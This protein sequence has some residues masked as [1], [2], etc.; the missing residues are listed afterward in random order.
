MAKYL[1]T[2]QT[3]STVC[4]LRSSLSSCMPPL[5]STTLNTRTLSSFVTT[6]C[7]ST[8]GIDKN[9]PAEIDYLNSKRTLIVFIELFSRYIM[10]SR[11]N[12][13]SFSRI[14]IGVLQTRLSF[15]K[16]VVHLLRSRHISRTLTC[17]VMR[18]KM[19]RRELIRAVG[20]CS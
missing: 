19:I 20:I 12:P 6:R 16:T 18:V 10:S 8:E 17:L 2:T 15:P 14:A 5:T 7:L 13:T 4:L 11:L 3:W 1:R 9:Y